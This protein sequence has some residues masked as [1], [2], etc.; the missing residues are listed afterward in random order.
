[1]IKRFV[2]TKKGYKTRIYPNQ[3]QK[4]LIN[5]TIGSCRWVY[6]Y[7]LEKAKING[8]ESKTKYIKQLPQLKNEHVWLKEVDS[9]ALQQ[10][11][12]DL[13]QAF[14]NFFD[15][16]QNYPQFKSKKHSRLSYRTQYFKRSSGTESIEIQNNKIKLPKLSWIEFNKHQEVKGNILNV[17]VSKEIDKYYISIN[18]KDVIVTEVNYNQGEIG[19]DL[20]I[21]DFAI[22]SDSEKIENPRHLQKYQDKLVRLQKKLARKEEGSNNWQKVKQKIVK[23]HR[24]IKNVRKDFLHKLSTRLVKE[25]QLIAIENLNIKGMLKN[26]KLAKHIQDVSWSKFVNMLE[27]KGKWY[28]CIV[29]KVNNFFPSSQTCSECGKKNPKVKDLSVR[30]WVCK[31]G[32]THDRDLN[33]SL[34]ILKQAKKQLAD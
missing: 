34:N 17:T 4:E 23:L 11:V 9:I 19:I 7:F 1:M 18:L 12:R 29:E 26:S 32:A 31:C 22:T 16:K 33:A 2:P 25:N 6:N 15:G 30:N 24:K 20:G 13:D 5:K 27:Y 14:Q 3:E 28:N 10:A 21:K 8:Y